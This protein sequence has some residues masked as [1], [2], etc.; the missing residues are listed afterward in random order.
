MPPLTPS[1]IR[2]PSKAAVTVRPAAG[3]AGLVVTL[4]GSGG[5]RLLVRSVG[6]VGRLHPRPVAF[7]IDGENGADLAGRDLLE[8]DRQRLTGNRGDL[9]GHDGSEAFAELAEVGVHL[10]APLG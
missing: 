2:R 10:P 6:L 5:D 3:S 9:R 4:A 1:T 8:S 7:A